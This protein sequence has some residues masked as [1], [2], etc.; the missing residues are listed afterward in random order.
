MAVIKNNY[1]FP[2]YCD[3]AIP[4]NGEKNFHATGQD[5]VD[6]IED[7]DL[8]VK[9][10]GDT[11]TGDL[12]MSGTSVGLITNRI[13]TNNNAGIRLSIEG[14]QHLHLI[15][16]FV[17]SYKPLQTDIILGRSGNVISC[18]NDRL[19]DVQ[20]PV[21]DQDAVTKKYLQDRILELQE[22][23]I[24]LEEEINA[25]FPTVIRGT[26]MYEE[27][28]NIPPK[29]HYALLDNN[30]A[31]TNDFLSVS[32]VLISE[33]DYASDAYGTQGFHTFVDVKVGQYLQILNTD[34]GNNEYGLYEI[35][36]APVYSSAINPYYT[37]EVNF[38]SDHGN[39]GDPVAEGLGRFKIFDPPFT[40]A[41]AYL[42]K[43]GDVATG[44][45]YLQD[46]NGDPQVFD[47]TTNPSTAVH[48]KY[49]DEHGA[50]DLDVA[51]TVTLAP[52]NPADVEITEQTRTEVTFKFSIPQG[53]TGERGQ[54]GNDGADGKNGRDGDSLCK[55]GKE[56]SPTLKTGEM[57]YNTDKNILIIG[58]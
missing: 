21:E 45:I 53:K 20:D 12:I 35:T 47:D 29:G 49:V 5:I 4:I 44:K 43:A 42:M 39:V 10:A 38:I 48:K 51:P 31:K 8:F 11:M 50:K 56:G 17:R 23:I 24:E 22:E 14:D 26:W 27:F 6:T 15:S 32:A 52:G 40:D 58:G 46:L 18:S 25:L 2:I 13:D 16:G 3:N 30:D 36:A 7:C 19:S 37:I 54:Q 55:V 34:V 41:D 9:K 33:E 28:N 57:Y 1:L